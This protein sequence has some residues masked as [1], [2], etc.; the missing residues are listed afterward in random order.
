[1]TLG[2]CSDPVLGIIHQAR[3]SS[4][5]VFLLPLQHDRGIDPRRNQLNPKADVLRSRRSPSSER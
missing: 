4:P 3:L 1:M 2:G 5:H